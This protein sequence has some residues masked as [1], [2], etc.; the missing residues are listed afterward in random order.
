MKLAEQLGSLMGQVCESA[1][2]RVTIE[3][4]GTVAGM[5]TR[6]LTAFVLKGVLSPMLEAVN[7]VSAPAIATTRGIAVSEVKHERESD[8]QSVLRVSVDTEKFKHSAAGTMFGEKSARVIEI[9]GIR[10]EAELAP[11][12]LYTQNHDKP[13]YVGRLGAT[14]GAAGINIATFHLGR[15]TKGGEAMA[16]LE[17]DLPIN[18][19]VLA[20]VS[21]LEGVAQAYV[22][23]FT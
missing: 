11:H 4:E 3:Y 19:E 15:N 17:V 2:K 18:E 5:N 9:D 10:T 14:I 1:V 8:Y 6:A 20:K 13:G 12:M 7:V 22:L 21:K 16:L 23:R